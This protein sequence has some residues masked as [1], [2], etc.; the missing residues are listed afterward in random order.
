METLISFL[1]VLIFGLI[2]LLSFGTF[3]YFSIN[4]LRKLYKPTPEEP[5]DVPAKYLEREDYKGII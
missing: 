3:W 5:N 4:W 2:C 1:F